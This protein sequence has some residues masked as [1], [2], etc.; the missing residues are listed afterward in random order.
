M[1]YIIVILIRVGV[2][3]IAFPF[4]QPCEYLVLTIIFPSVFSVPVPSAFPCR[5]WLLDLLR[6]YC[7]PL[8]SLSLCVH[9]EEP[10]LLFHQVMLSHW[11]KA[12]TRPSTTVSHHD[13]FWYLNLKMSGFCLGSVT[14]LLTRIKLLVLCN[15]FCTELLP[16]HCSSLEFCENEYLTKWPTTCPSEIAIHLLK[17]F[18]Q[19]VK[20]NLPCV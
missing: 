1:R 5:L 18:P 14:A 16:G 15:Q 3:N 13:L 2:K 19:L 20:M 17:P 6:F 12:R 8:D 10:R 11:G 4:K 9:T 7:P